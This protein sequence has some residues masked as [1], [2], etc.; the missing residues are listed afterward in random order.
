MDGQLVEQWPQHPLID[1][2]QHKSGDSKIIKGKQSKVPQPDLVQGYSA[3]GPD[4]WVSVA[5]YNQ[6]GVVISAVG[7]RCG[8][9]FLAQGEWTSLLSHANP[10][11]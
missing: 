4:I 7:A 10:G 2:V 8:K 1:F 9:A 3:S 11:S 5:K 6:P